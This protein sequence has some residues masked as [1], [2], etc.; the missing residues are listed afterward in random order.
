MLKFVVLI[1]LA[2]C[3]L[4][5]TVPEGLLPQLDGRIV[6]GYDT[7]I[8]AHPYQVSLQR[9][10]AHFCGGSVYSHDIIVTAAHCLQSVSAKD[11]RV[12]V[13]TTYWREGGSVHSVKSFRNHEGYNKRTMINDIA[14]IRLESSISFDSSVRPIDIAEKNPANDAEAIVTGWGT[15]KS[16]GSIPDHLLAVDLRIVNREECASKEYKYGSQIK[17][18]MICAYAVHKDACQGDSGG[19]LV[20]GGRLVGVVSWGKGCAATGYP[21]VYADVAH[22]HSWVEST[23]REL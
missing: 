15:T 9:N 6:G 13:G 22:F 16:G 23:A 8:E 11:L 17:D 21:G 10:G 12:R 18:T 3:V 14:I 19:P 1:S 2:A 4:A 5:G 20:S 7:S